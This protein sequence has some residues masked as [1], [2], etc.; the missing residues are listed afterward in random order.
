VILVPGADPSPQAATSSPEPTTR[1]T[2]KITFLS[3]LPETNVEVGLGKFGKKG[4]LGYEI[5]GD[6][7]IVVGKVV[8][9][10]GLSLHP[11]SDDTSRVRYWLGKRFRWFEGK[12]AINDTS[13]GLITVPVFKV[14]GDNKQLWKSMQLREPGASAEIA[15]DVTGVEW[16]ELR[17]EC[18]GD[19]SGAHAVWVEPRVRDNADPPASRR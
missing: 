14:L 17:V 10:H 19:N 1:P 8:S 12:A 6:H 9:P 15:V 3:D 11:A 5:E 2:P 18:A 7:R 13:G 4:D 16:L